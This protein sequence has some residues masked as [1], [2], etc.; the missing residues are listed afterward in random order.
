MDAAPSTVSALDLSA[1]ETVLC[2]VPETAAGLRL[3]VFLA[4]VLSVSRARIQRAI[5]D[6]EVRVNGQVRR[7]SYRV[8]PG[9][10]IEADVPAPVTTDLVPED[11]PLT[12]RFEDEAILVLEKPAGQVVHPAA[13]VTHGTLANALA[14]H[15]G[16]QR[17][18]AEP[19][20]PGI[21]HRLDRDTS[22]LMVVA[23]TD[24][25]LE[26]LAGQFRARTVEKGYLALVHGD[27]VGAGTI[28]APIARDRKHRLKMTVDPGGRPARSHYVVRQRFGPVTLLEVRIETGRTHQIRVHCAYIRHPVVG[29]PLYGLGRDQQL[30]H[31]SQRQAVERLGRQF[32]HAAHLAFV[33]PVSAQPMRF[34]SL[35][36]PDLQGCLVA[37]AGSEAH[38]S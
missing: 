6:G 7:A 34:V 10:D 20:R 1:A 32:L 15:F 29:D 3:D 22:G 30:R 8:E 13:G 17:P 21:V 23:K 26:H 36:P 5:A 18:G 14:F 16:Q 33:H 12:I 28:D 4:E 35:L 2:R 25:A 31:P 11:L 27:V 37:F 38:L 9:D 19:L 24:A